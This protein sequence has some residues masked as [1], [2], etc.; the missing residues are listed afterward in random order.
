MDRLEK[1][2]RGAL[3]DL[4]ERGRTTRV[5]AKARAA[6]VACTRAQRAAGVPWRDIAGSL[7]LS[8]ESLRRWLAA[9]TEKPGRQRAAPLVAPVRVRPEA[10]SRG[11][12]LVT[13]SGH[14]IEGLTL[15][16]ALVALRVLS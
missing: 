16:D 4:G 10:V 11:L 3:A 1:A 12:A 5:P 14:R 13:A 6:V 8:P 2:A 9:A 7:G 15:D